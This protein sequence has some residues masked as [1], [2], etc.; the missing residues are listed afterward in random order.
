MNTRSTRSAASAAIASFVL[1]ALPALPAPPAPPLYDAYQAMTV[2]ELDEETRMIRE[3]AYLRSVGNTSQRDIDIANDI[4]SH[5]SETIYEAFHAFISFCLGGQ[6]DVYPYLATKCGANFSV[7]NTKRKFDA[8]PNNTIFNDGN[9]T[10][11]HYKYKNSRGEIKDP[12]DLYQLNLTHGNCLFYALFLACQDIQGKEDA[13]G[14][15]LF[16]IQPYLTNAT[17]PPQQGQYTV[18]GE[19]RKAN[20][21]KCLVLNDYRIMNWIFDKFLNP[22][23]RFILNDM[24]TAIKDYDIRKT[25]DIVKV[26]TP[27]Q[28]LKA[29]K[30]LLRNINQ[31]F[32]MTFEQIE[33]WDIQARTGILPYENSGIPGGVNEDD[34]AGGKKSKKSKRNSK[35]RRSRRSKRSK[36]S[37]GKR[38]TKKN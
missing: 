16:S 4:I 5:G 37:G 32:K 14:V 34:Y 30:P 18:I 36:R 3:A 1:P 26:V 27:Y 6:D 31:T 8:L 29:F 10:E 35:S 17:F 13:D 23:D 11:T 19:A 12:Y 20:A 33:N 22:A 9:E 24:D 21:Y 7:A 15:H 25:Y 38:R 28:F 2:Y